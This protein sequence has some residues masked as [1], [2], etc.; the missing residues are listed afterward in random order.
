M[1]LL[2]EKSL[3][4]RDLHLKLHLMIDAIL[5]SFIHLKTDKLIELTAK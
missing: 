1:L 3:Y 4:I 5:F 2:P